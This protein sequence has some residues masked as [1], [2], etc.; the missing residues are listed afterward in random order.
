MAWPHA[1]NPSASGHDWALSALAPVRSLLSRMPSPQAG[2]LADKRYL[3]FLF[4][5]TVLPFYY[6]ER[7]QTTLLRAEDVTQPLRCVA[8]SLL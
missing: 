3:N 1:T 6:R 7:G 5:N 8:I 4:E 2:T